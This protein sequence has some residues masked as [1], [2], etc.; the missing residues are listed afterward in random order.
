MTL[1]QLVFYAGLP[2]SILMFCIG[3]KMSLKSFNT[4][5]KKA[6]L[7]AIGLTGLI[8]YAVVIMLYLCEQINWNYK[9]F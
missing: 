2:L 9:V 1:L 7:Q 8:C 3:N 6:L 4:I 5:F